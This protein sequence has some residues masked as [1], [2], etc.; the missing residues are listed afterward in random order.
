M[1]NNVSILYGSKTGNAEQ[2]SREIYH[3]LLQKGYECKHSSLN[4]SL[5]KDSF[6]FL[7]GDRPFTVIVVCSTTGNGDAPESADHF[8]SKFKN[9]NEP[10]NLCESIEYAVLGLGDTNYEKFCEIGKKIDR[11]FHELGGKRILDL[12]CCDEAV[13]SEEMI[14]LFIKKLMMNF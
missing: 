9:R 12:H 6:S 14:E 4:K 10:K 5:E 13:G 3:L 11:R 2:I 1:Q 7:Q 8:W